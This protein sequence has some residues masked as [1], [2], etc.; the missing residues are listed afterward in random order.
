MALMGVNW[1]SGTAKPSL[2][3]R[4]DNDIGYQYIIS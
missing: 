4:N 2:S 3:Q 1:D